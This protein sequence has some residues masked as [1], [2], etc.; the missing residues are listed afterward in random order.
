MRRRRRCRRCCSRTRLVSW[1]K[2]IAMAAI[3]GTRLTRCGF[4]SASRVRIAHA[5][6]SPSPQPSPA[7]GEGEFIERCRKNPARQTRTGIK[8]RGSVTSGISV[9]VGCAPRTRLI[10]PHPNPL[11][12]GGKFI[13]RC[14]KNPARKARTQ[15]KKRGSV[16]SGIP[17]P[18]GCAP[19][20]RLIPP[21][22]NPFPRG[23]RENSLSVVARIRRVKLARK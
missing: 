10:P 14:R 12:R 23:E 8:K 20:T 22:P 2:F 16:T 1:R 21:H 4:S 9:P 19:R 15:I 11:P 7:R 17:V 3:P 13:E 18:V 6:H 5:A